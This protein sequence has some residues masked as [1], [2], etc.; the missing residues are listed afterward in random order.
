MSV[1]STPESGDTVSIYEVNQ[2]LESAV[3][4]SVRKQQ[5]SIIKSPTGSGKSYTVATTPWKNYP[6]ITG[7]QPVIHVHGTRTARDEAAAYSEKVGLSSKILKNR[8]ELCPVANGDYDEELNHI[9]GLPV[10]EWIDQKC[11]VENNSYSSVRRHLKQELGDVPGDDGTVFRQWDTLLR[12]EDGTPTYDIVHTTANFLYIDDLAKG[13]NIIFDEQPDYTITH[14]YRNIQKTANRLLQEHTDTRYTWEGLLEAKHEDDIDY[15][16]EIESVL[17][18]GFTNDWWNLKREGNRLIEQILRAVINANVT[19][20]EYIV[21]TTGNLSIEINRENTIKTIR[22]IPDLTTA[23][24]LIG[25][26]AHPSPYRWELETGI[27][28]TTQEILNEVEAK[29]WRRNQRQ[30]RVI[31]VGNR[32]YSLTNGWGGNTKEIAEAVIKA[33]HERHGAEFKTCICSKAIEQDI[34]Q[35]MKAQ[36]IDSP[37]VQHYGNLK[38]TNTF[39]GETVGLVFGRIDLGTT[40]VLAMAESLGLDVESIPTTEVNHSE[41]KF[42]GPDASA[43][44]ELLDSVRIG[45]VQQAVGR[46]ARQARNPDDHA[47]VYVYTNTLPKSWVDEQTAGVTQEVTEDVRRIENF[48]QESS[49]S[50]TKKNIA[51]ETGISKGW[52]STVLKRMYEAGLVSKSEGTGKYGADEFKYIAGE[53]KFEVDIG[54]R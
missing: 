6:T 1:T 47:T 34:I 15:V 48:I 14:K 41:H 44:Q 11:D 28:F 46:Y 25:L 49:D 13:A 8:K 40:S 32:S 31:Q 7:G 37:N 42:T 29:W 43:A 18:I 38:S 17:N 2:R 45:E 53:L 24:S 21:G 30:L 9:D 10:S 22:K 19:D 51:D 52:V 4:D 35:I 3:Y 39:T 50:V 33:I 27:G 23:R 5:K 26:D 54:D 16:A 12:D 20:E 36:G